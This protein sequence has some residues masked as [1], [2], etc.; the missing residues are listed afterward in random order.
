[1]RPVR[2][3]IFDLDGTLLDT[4]SLVLEVAK[5]VVEQHGYTL[6]PD[7]QR[8]GLGRTPIDAWNAVVENL[9]M[10]GVTPEQ[11]F[12]ES[13]PLLAARWHEAKLLPGAGRLLWHLHRHGVPVALA[14]STSRATLK[15]KMSGRHADLLNIFHTVNCG[16]ENERGK[17][18]PDCFRASAAKLQV[19]PAECLV[20]E[21]A[22]SGIAAATAAGMRVVAVPSMVTKGLQQDD[23]PPAQEDAGAGCCSTLSSLFDFHPEVYGLPPFDDLVART[24]PVSPV[25]R[26]RGTV[27]KGFGRGSR[28][29]R[30]PTANLD[31]ESLQGVLA[32]A[33]TGIYCGWA[34][35]GNDSA[36]HKMVMS[37]GW[38]PF[39]NNEEK[40]AEPW[41]LHDFAEDFYGAELRLLVCGYIRPEANF[42]SL[43]VLIARIHEDA[44]ISR[45]ALDE[46]VYAQLQTDPSLKPVLTSN[47]AA[48]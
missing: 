13:E 30:I 38:N 22:P 9:Q 7:A 5:A 24:V 31:R 33:V 47:P 2:A 20:I 46:S 42:S 41:I 36:V 32:E 25:W 23:C 3:V 8:A 26:I 6:T 14:T 27:V 37:I 21:D 18:A 44:N 16:D 43:E 34:S 29:L 12:A 40:T 35:V 15:R 11:L 4:E 19:D 10:K 1:M 39:Y 28:E 45:K 48:A 17:P